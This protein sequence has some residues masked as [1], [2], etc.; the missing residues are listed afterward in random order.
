ML[1]VGLTGNIA[2]GKSTVAAALVSRGATL[3]D[4][5]VAARAAVAPGTP[6]LAAITRRFGVD[7]LQAD[8][9]LDRARLG[10]RVFADV[11]ARHALEQIVHPAVE[12][13][14]QTALRFARQRGDQIVICDIPLL[15]E[16]RL[17]FQFARIVLVDAPPAMRVAR[18]MYHRGMS[19]ADAESRVRAQLSA[20]VKH[21]RADV[22]IV[23]DGDLDGLMAQ[24]ARTWSR[25]Q[26]W[27]AV[28]APMQAAQAI[29]HV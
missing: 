24:I 18:L 7:L 25:L 27:T 11:A 4:S 20:T 6:A 26:E 19:Q 17:A 1:I 28:G 13:A 29:S 21:G 14:R 15:F 16:A 2:S 12:A 5:D 22:V 23:N 9:T 8:G 10:H 3:I